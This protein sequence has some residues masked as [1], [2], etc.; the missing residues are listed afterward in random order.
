MKIIEPYIEV[1]NFNGLQIMKN[2]ERACR[3]CYRSEDK[4]TDESYKGLLSNCITRGHES[5]LEH[6]KITV[7]MVCDVG[8]FSKDTKVLTT[9]GWK[10]FFELQPW[11][12]VFTLDDN[13]NVIEYPIQTI[14]SKDYNGDMYHFRNTALDLL[15]TPDHKMWVFDE[16]KRAITSKIWKF[17]PAKDMKNSTYKF[18]KIGN[19]TRTDIKRTIK[20][21][22]RTYANKEVKSGIE[23]DNLLLYEL[24]GWFITDGSIEKQGKS[25]R[26]RIHQKKEKGKKRIQ[27]LLEALNIPYSYYSGTFS[28]KYS[29][30]SNF[31]YSLCYKDKNT[32]KSINAFVPDFVRLAGTNEIE[33]FLK[34]VFGGDGTIYKD[35]RQLIYTASEQFAQDLV[36]LFFRIGKTANYYPC[37]DMSKYKKTYKQTTQC[38]CVSVS[39]T[40][41]SYWQRNRISQEKENFSI[42]PYNDKVY[43]I[44]LEKYHRI[45]VMRNGKTAWCGQCYK[46][47][48]RHRFGSF[49]IEST[50][51]CNY[52]KDRFDNEIK[53][54]KPVF[55]DE[56][57]IDCN[58]EGSSMNKNQQISK[59]WYESIQNMEQNYNAMSELGAKPDQLRMILP[60]STSAEVTMTANIREWKHI[61]DL[62][63]K[64]MAH[65][66]VQQLMIPLLL[67]FKEEM[68]EIFDSV[69]YNQDFPKE[70]YAEL[71][72]ME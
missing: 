41:I 54:I 69:E 43:C 14:I 31:F 52:G 68:P 42:E 12:K 56:S 40:E 20:I 15:V 22:N 16:H 25:S 45:F 51:Y 33:A 30:L 67:K 71:K 66:S 34:G 58:Y 64:K 11:H 35:G 13:N 50:R 60:H 1:E 57:W 37:P 2:I 28:I 44:S 29:L 4:I 6:E 18:N 17:I 24:L 46:D 53:V 8:C 9:G 48:T 72:V 7:R 62:R 26:M 21:P 39:R 3:T 55:Y 23:V 63:T 36:E 10:Y 49:S 5:V 32:K 19:K 47:L 61:L 70:L 38:F 65:P 27:F 59:Y